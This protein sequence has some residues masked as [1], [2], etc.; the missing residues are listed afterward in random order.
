MKKQRPLRQGVLR[1]EQTDSEVRELCCMFKL[2]STDHNCSLHFL[3][4]PHPVC[5]FSSMLQMKAGTVQAAHMTHISL[6]HSLSKLLLYIIFSSEEE[7]GKLIEILRTARGSLQ[8]GLAFECC[9]RNIVITNFHFTC[10]S[11]SPGVQFS[12]KILDHKGGYHHYES[13]SVILIT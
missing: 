12:E 7:S 2:R 13:D 4:F 10:S 1:R 5:H 11:M 6:N 8:M 9:L 3:Q